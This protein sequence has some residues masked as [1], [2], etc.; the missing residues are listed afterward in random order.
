MVLLKRAVTNVLIGD[1][2]RLL[3]WISEPPLCSCSWVSCKKGCS[4]HIA[5]HQCSSEVV[6]L[7]CRLWGNPSHFDVLTSILREK[8]TADQLHILATKCNSGHF[9]YD[10]IELGGERVA[11]EIEEALVE[12]ARAGHNIKKL[13]VVGYSLGGLI[14]RYAIGLLYH[15]GVFDK[16]Q[17]VVGS[18]LNTLV[19][20]LLT[21]RRTI[22]LL[23][24]LIS[25]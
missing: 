18:V 7:F 3:C 17:P 2:P 11:N 8:Y 19:G 24:L 1:F 5:S 13:S 10:G 9:T 15:K 25:G 16:I 23:P 20:T 14:S 21:L 12:L 4:R 6:N 22:R